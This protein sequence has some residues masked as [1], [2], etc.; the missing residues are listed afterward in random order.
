MS[1]VNKQ[2][3]DFTV[4]CPGLW[5]AVT[6]D[7]SALRAM[8]MGTCQRKSAMLRRWGV[9]VRPKWHHEGRLYKLPGAGCEC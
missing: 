9:L 1:L 8:D 7:L 6:L 4:G 3:R 5:R 2:L